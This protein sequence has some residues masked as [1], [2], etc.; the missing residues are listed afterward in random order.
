MAEAVVACDRDLPEIPGRRRW[1]R[2]ERPASYLVRDDA[3]RSGGG[4]T[5]RAGAR[6]VAGG[7]GPRRVATGIDVPF[8]IPGAL[9]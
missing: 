9:T 7:S 6:G 1:S 2:W 4:W 8:C 3:A 5:T